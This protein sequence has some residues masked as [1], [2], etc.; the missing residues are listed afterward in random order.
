MNL[1]ASGDRPGLSNE[2][3]ALRGADIGRDF[4]I[5]RR[6]ALADSAA[7]I[8][9]GAVAGTEPAAIVAGVIEWH[10]T[11]MGTD[12]DDDQPITREESRR[13]E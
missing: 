1:L 7:D 5:E 11:Q 4:K 8:V 6:G 3:L 13:Q 9:V 10:T 12:T 2:E